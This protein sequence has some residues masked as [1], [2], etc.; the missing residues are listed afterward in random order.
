MSKKTKAA[1]PGTFR[2]IFD[3]FDAPIMSVDCGKHCMPLNDGVPVCCDT[4]NAIPV[5]QKAEWKHLRTR[6][7]MWG[8]FTPYDENSQEIVDE[9]SDSCKAVECKGFKKCERDNRSLACRT[10]PFFPY[11]TKDGELLGLSY[12][13]HFEDTCWVISNMKKVDQR[14][15]DQFLE[16]YEILFADD[17]EEL[18]VFQDY[19]ASQRRVFSRRKQDIPVINRKGKVLLIRPKGKGV[20]KGSLKDLPKFAPFDE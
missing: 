8:K 11:F 15:I 17:D 20:K 7:K 4:G 13:W 18:E 12:Y 16:A 19:S 9:L 3:F 2:K 10:F 6:S 1:T 14:F 5:M